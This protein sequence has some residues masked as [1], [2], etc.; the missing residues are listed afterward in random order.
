MTCQ[1]WEVAGLPDLW[2]PYAAGELRVEVVPGT[3][4]GMVAEPY[5]QILAEVIE[6]VITGVPAGVG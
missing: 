1:G 5:V 4:V 2:R 3:H 6:E